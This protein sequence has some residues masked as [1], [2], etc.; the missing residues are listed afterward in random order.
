MQWIRNMKITVKLIMAFLLVTIIMIGVGWIGITNMGA[1]ND[2]DTQLYERE[3]LGLGAIK[4]TNLRLH[5][6]IRMEK[7]F[8][9]ASTKEKKDVYAFRLA[10]IQ[11][12]FQARLAEAKPKFVTEKGKQLIA[13]LETVFAEWK[14]VQEETFRLAQGE[15]LTSA[16]PSVILNLTTGQDK[17]SNLDEVLV[18]LG[19][20]KQERAKQTADD[21]TD[22]YHTSRKYMIILIVVAA[23]LGLLMGYGISRSITVP[24]NEGVRLAEA[25]SHGDLTQSIQ[26]GNRKDEVGRLGEAMYNMAEKLREV[27]GSMNTASEQVAAG[28]DMLSQGA[29]EQAAS[30]EETSSAMEQM[31]ANIQQN[32]D[33]AA[34]TEKIAQQAAS[35]A[36]EG[37]TAVAETVKAMK[38][39]A[40]KIAIIQK[41]ADQTNL[42]ALN[43]AIEAARA[44]EHG[45]GFAVVADEVRKLAEGSE[46]AASEIN[47]LST[48]S[49]E[50]AERAGV[51]LKKLVPDIKKTAELVQ[52]IAAASREQ[53]QGAVQINQSVQ[54][55]DQ[56]I[57]Q[58]AGASEELSSQAEQMRETMAFFNLGGQSG[59]SHRARR[60]VPPK[61]TRSKTVQNKESR[62]R[63]LPA[64]QNSAGRKLLRRPAAE[65]GSGV[66]LDMD[67]NGHDDPDQEFEKF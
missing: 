29:T 21:N 37:G 50:K 5:D 19:D 64:P 22:L 28:S 3:L 44:G 57:Q 30:I 41:L 46:Q 54:Q 48:S 18:E 58:N 34:Q 60:S 66:H 67:T 15:E 10:E 63:S 16:K 25:L 1:L 12:Q 59:G 9:L 39:I 14:S 26:S 24:L 53:N 4:D 35:D 49:V 43:A 38:E 45:K 2:A 62:P 51:L 61:V 23:V 42:L 55:L 32:T 40:E 65:Q 20:G 13:K 31:T 6:M 17:L 56:V 52:E 27:V 11:T 47:N 7:N 36:M 8:L 33:N